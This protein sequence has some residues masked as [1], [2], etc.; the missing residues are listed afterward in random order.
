VKSKE[1]IYEPQPLYID[2]VNNRFSATDLNYV[3]GVGRHLY[4]NFYCGIRF[5]YSII[6]IRPA[7]RIPVGY[8]YGSEGQ[9]NN[10]FSVRFMYQL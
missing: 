2:E 4:K 8:G 9:Y 6:N 5:Q 10:L 7:D 3:L 1:T